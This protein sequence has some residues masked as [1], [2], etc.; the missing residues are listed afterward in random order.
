[1]GAV[2]ISGFII[3]QSP[4][5]EIRNIASYSAGCASRAP[6][7]IK[8]RIADAFYKPRTCVPIS[9]AS[10][11]E[12]I[13]RSLSMFSI[14][15]AAPIAPEPARTLSHPSL[16][17]TRAS[18]TS[19]DIK[20]RKTILL[21]LLLLSPSIIRAGG[22]GQNSRR[23]MAHLHHNYAHVLRSRACAHTTLRH[24][25]N[26]SVLRKVRDMIHEQFQKSAFRHPCLCA[27]FLRLHS[28]ASTRVGPPK[29]TDTT[30]GWG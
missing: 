23:A 8:V 30:A 7:L 14:E 24:D 6:E 10:T 17:H 15:I 22:P 27:Q 4:V 1:M 26:G 3:E 18:V 13:E 28:S 20:R 19:P 25:D 11:Q 12:G 9:Y 5:S 2:S 29:V 21:P 16:A